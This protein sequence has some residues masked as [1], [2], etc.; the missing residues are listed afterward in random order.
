VLG[1][2]MTHDANCITHETGHTP[3]EFLKTCLD[4]EYIIII[5]KDNVYV[6]CSK[7][8]YPGVFNLFFCNWPKPNFSLR[9][10]EPKLYRDVRKDLKITFKKDKNSF[11]IL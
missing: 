6:D 1:S 5:F 4:V 9:H 10:R 8:I 2:K 7:C 11:I 3:D